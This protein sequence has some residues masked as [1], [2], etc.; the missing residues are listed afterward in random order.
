MDLDA[1]ELQSI[2]M[3]FVD[4]AH[5]HLITRQV[6]NDDICN[7]IH[8]NIVIIATQWTSMIILIS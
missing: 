1:D 3:L 7:L 6:Y 5:Y 2:I 8:S 4:L